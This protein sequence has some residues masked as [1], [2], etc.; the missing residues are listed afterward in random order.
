MYAIRKGQLR[1]SEDAPQTLAEQFSALAAEITNL[2]HLVSR[3]CS[4][5]LLSQKPDQTGEGQEQFLH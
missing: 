2:L 4:A 5:R 3:L 1:T